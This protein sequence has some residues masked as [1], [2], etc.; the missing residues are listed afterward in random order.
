MTASEDFA[1]VAARLEAQL[2]AI[3]NQIDHGERTSQQIARLADERLTAR[4]DSIDR[5]LTDMDSARERARKDD[6]HAREAI[7]LKQTAVELRVTALEKF[8]HAGVEKT[9]DALARL[10]LDTVASD[11]G[12]LKKFKWT[13]FG[14][15]IGASAAGGGLA[16]VIANALGGT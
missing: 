9:L 4:F 13:L 3:K 1:V 2:E 11:V 10:N 14:I 5:R 7:E 6:L 15:C 16:A 8:D 12:D